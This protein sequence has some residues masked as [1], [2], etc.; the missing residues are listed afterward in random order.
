[1][2]LSINNNYGTV[3]H[4]EN[5][6]VTINNSQLTAE[7]GE[8]VQLADLVQAGG[9]V[10]V[11]Q[12]T[13]VEDIEQVATDPQSALP[14]FVPE[15]LAELGTA[16]AEEFDALYHSAVQAGA[17]KLATFIKHYRGLQVLNTKG[18][19]KKKT[20][21]QLKAYFGEELGFGYA[22]FAAYY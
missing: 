17:P 15:K 16:T 7:P 19:N 22:N 4:I 6:N 21:E 9:E 12:E 13:S 10:T 3:N 8:P 20:Y 14:F 5:S 1:M 2:S 18:Y 11:Q